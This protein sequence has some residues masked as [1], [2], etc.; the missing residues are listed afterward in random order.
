M[1]TPTAKTANNSL[2]VTVHLNTAKRWKVVPLARF[3][4]AVLPQLSGLPLGHHSISSSPKT[5]QVQEGRNFPQRTT[6]TRT[7]ISRIHGCFCLQFAMTDRPE[8]NHALFGPMHFPSQLQWS[9]VRHWKMSEWPPPRSQL[10][11][12]WSKVTLECSALS[13]RL[14]LPWECEMEGFDNG[15]VFVQG[16]KNRLF[17]DVFGNK[18][19]PFSTNQAWKYKVPCTNGPNITW[20]W[21]YQSRFDVNEPLEVGPILQWSLKYGRNVE[22]EGSL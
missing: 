5:R 20:N 10:P 4:N 1:L 18:T 17:D 14:H 13:S 22:I 15:K 19:C 21:D 2:K 11:M 9:Q 7:T 16:V 8:T 6:A 12:V 3:R